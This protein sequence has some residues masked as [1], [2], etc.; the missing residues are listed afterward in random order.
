MYDVDDE[1]A[2]KLGVEL[3]K[4]HGFAPSSADMPK[5]VNLPKTLLGHTRKYDNDEDVNRI[6]STEASDGR[7]R[8]TS[9][10]KPQKVTTMTKVHDGYVTQTTNP[11]KEDES[12]KEVVTAQGMNDQ[13]AQTWLQT[14]QK[15]IKEVPEKIAALFK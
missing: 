13:E 7:Q 8:A 1:T 2:Y 11:G 12:Y 9:A 14:A 5:I 6:R 3:K 10:F 4:R 15:L